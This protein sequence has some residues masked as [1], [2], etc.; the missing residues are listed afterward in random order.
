MHLYSKILHN[1]PNMLK[2]SELID[3]KKTH[4]VKKIVYLYLCKAYE[5]RKNTLNPYPANTESD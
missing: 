3:C 4:C 5:V 1:R 2:L